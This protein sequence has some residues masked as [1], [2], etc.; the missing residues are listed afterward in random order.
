MPHKEIKEYLKQNI[1][2]LFEGINDLPPE[3]R[4]PLLIRLLDYVE[5]LEA[6]EANLNRCSNMSDAELDAEIS[7]YEKRN[8]LGR[9]TI[10]LPEPS[11]ESK[12]RWENSQI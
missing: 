5:K 2:L 11:H 6:K 1:N 12:E 8:H 3:K 4:T 7:A 9:V 10:Q